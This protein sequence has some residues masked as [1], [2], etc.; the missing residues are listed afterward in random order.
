MLRRRWQRFNLLIVTRDGTPVRRVGVRPSVV[1]AGLVLFTLAFFAAGTLLGDYVALRSQRAEFFAHRVR[2]HE[3]EA[4]LSVYQ[5]RLRELYGELQG[6]REIRDR[7]WAAFGPA[8]APGTPDGG[9]GGVSTP[10]PHAEALRDAPPRGRPGPALADSREAIRD[11]LERLTAVVKEEGE[12][13]RSLQQFISRATR[14]L[15]ALPSRW[16]LRGPINSD[17]GHRTSPWGGGS[18][19]HGGIDIGAPVGTP[20]HAPAPGVVAFAGRHG[21]Y[22]I[23][24]MI[25]HGNDVRSLYGHLSRLHVA[26]G[27]DV[28]R[29]DLIAS[30]GNTGRSSGPH[31]HY[32][33]H[34]AGQPVNPY[35]FL[36]E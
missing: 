18:E 13:L 20:V 26:A 3:Q 5:G 11:E 23:A 2:V 27:Q 8:A 17:F 36:W 28:K 1:V 14:A 31:L 15:A 21:E 16:P 34:A 35:T 22:G 12:G 4:Q 32:E 10:V 9:I 7:V 24:V 6:W 30:S 19:Y 25:D 33:I 29:G